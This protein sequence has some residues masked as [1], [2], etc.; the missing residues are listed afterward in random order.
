MKSGVLTLVLSGRIAGELSRER[1]RLLLRYSDAWRRDPDTYPLSLSLP[2]ATAEHTA[3]RVEP[4][5]WGLLPENPLVLDRWARQFQV[6][7]GSPFAMLAHVGEDCPGAVQLIRPERL[8][9]IREG[10]RR[11]VVWLESSQIA[12]RLRELRRDQAAWRDPGDH[13]QFSLAGA[14]PK[15]AFLFE[16]GRYG[17]PAGRTATTHILKPPLQ[18]LHGHA[19]N[20]HLCLA[21]ARR[22]GIPSAHSVVQRFDDELAIV[23]ERY[24]RVHLAGAWIRVHQEDTCQA[25]GLSPAVKYQSQ[26]GPTPARVIELLRTYSS[27]ASAD[28]HTFVD[29]LIFNWLIGGTDAHAKNYSLLLAAHGQA[30]LAPLYDLAS[31]LVYRHFDPQKLKLAMKI[32]SS[33]RL[34]DIE[35]RHWQV[36]A[37]EAKLDP[38]A[39]VERARTLAA[40]LSGELEALR[41]AAKREGLRP[42]VV[43]RIAKA[44]GA[45]AKRCQAKLE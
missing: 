3:A 8:D 31:A 43:D 2:L 22:L 28:V 4:F 1:G 17:V 14:Q 18:D 36:F 42:T 7:A 45:H 6:S 40:Q 16:N 27:A 44:L 34:R 23:V 11:E 29:A 21:L 24:D 39:V 13:G 41:T 38:G 33:Y 37:R 12:A 25:L 30:R 26:G 9:A 19:E 15:T 35:R 5:L 32:G 10:A 20:E